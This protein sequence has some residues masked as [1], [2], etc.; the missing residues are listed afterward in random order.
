MRNTRWA[1][2]GTKK[3]TS[4]V[5]NVVDGED[6]PDLQLQITSQRIQMT[7]SMLAKQRD[8]VGEGQ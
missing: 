8:E 7:R 5:R 1:F 4:T 6:I 2:T 3:K